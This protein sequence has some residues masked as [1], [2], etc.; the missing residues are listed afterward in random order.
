VSPGPEGGAARNAEAAKAEKELADAQGSLTS[1]LA[2][3]AVDVAGIVDPTPI[4]D[5]IGAGMSLFKGDLIGAG[6]SLISIIPYVGD[7]F[8]KTAKGARATAKINKIRKTISHLTRKLRKLKK[9][10]ASSVKARKA[11]KA[12][13][14]LPA[15]VKSVVQR[16]PTKIARLAGMLPESAEKV[17]DICKRNKVVITMRNTNPESVKWLKKGYPPKP[18]ALKMKTIQPL[19]ELLGAPKGSS[20]LVGYFRPLKPT[21]A[22]KRLKKAD[23]AAYK[24]F[25]SDPENIKNLNKRAKK[26]FKEFKSLDTDVQK[27]RG[28]GKIK[29]KKGVVYDTDSRKA[30]AGDHDIFEIR[31]ANGTAASAERKAK[32]LEELKEPPVKAQ[33]PA[34]M[35][36]DTK[37]AKEASIKKGIIEDHQKGDL[38]QF[39][40]YGAAQVKVKPKPKSGT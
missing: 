35:D 18:M 37:S 33:H 31:N 26:R 7:A 6:L 9:S 28:K 20:G 21:E 4:S 29:V 5:L 17:I 10:V 25:I 11:V 38:T 22:M 14:K 36:W 23:P 13:K 19:D 30:F 40:K 16:C 2:Q 39:S 32:V 12:S 34:H 15:M 27:L 1:E 3:A 8:A 24:K